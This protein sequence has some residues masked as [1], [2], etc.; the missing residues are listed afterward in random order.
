MEWLEAVYPD[1]FPNLPTSGMTDVWPAMERKAGSLE[2]VR[3]LRTHAELQA[4][5]NTTTPSKTKV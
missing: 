2:V 5:K 3:L 4:Q 1:R